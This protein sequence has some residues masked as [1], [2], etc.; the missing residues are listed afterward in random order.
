M[1]CGR[2]F[3]IDLPQKALIWEDQDAVYL[4]YN[5]PSYLA[6]RHHLQGCDELIEKTAQVLAELVSTATAP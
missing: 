1:E 4:G 5:D 3:A 6:Q 2:T